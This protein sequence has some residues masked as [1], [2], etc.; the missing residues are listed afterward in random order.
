MLQT[1]T[2]PNISVEVMGFGAPAGGV[3]CNELLRPTHQYD[4]SSGITRSSIIQ[5]LSL[6]VG[7]LDW[8]KPSSA[9]G[10]L[11][12]SCKTVT[13]HVLDHA[14]NAPGSTTDTTVDSLDLD[15]SSNVND[16]FN[17][18]L[19]DTFDWLRSDIGSSQESV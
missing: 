13:Q 15:I 18:E 1:C 4:P 6:L 12:N 8:V 2:I 5:Q 7:F 9:N 3:L 11:C 14:L 10:D 17:F 19:L 16:F